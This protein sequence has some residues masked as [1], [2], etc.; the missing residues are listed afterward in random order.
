MQDAL[1]AYKASVFQALAHPTRI[2][3]VEILRYGELS[4]R[5]LQERLGIEQANLS[6]HLAILRSRQL[7]LNR[8]DGNQVFYSLRNPV[9]MELLDIMRRYFQTN[10]A[11]AVQMLGEIDREATTH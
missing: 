11:E 5:T 10:L 1:R 9:L 8:K 3:I 7:V 6:Q 4:T 2:A